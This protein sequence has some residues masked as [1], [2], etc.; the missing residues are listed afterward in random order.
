MRDINPAKDTVLQYW[1]P[2]WEHLSRFQG[3]VLLC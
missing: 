2:T 3:L 1:S